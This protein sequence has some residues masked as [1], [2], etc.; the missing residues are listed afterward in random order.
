MTSSSVRRF[1]ER[2]DRW[3]RSLSQGQYAIFLGLSAGVGVLIAGLAISRELFV[4]Q[5]LTM[6]VVMFG[7]E[8]KFGLP[9]SSAE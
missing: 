3:V 6:A 2:A 1:Y 8:Y 7:L 5:S 9:H 4:L